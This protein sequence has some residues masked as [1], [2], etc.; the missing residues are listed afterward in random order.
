VLNQCDDGG[1]QTAHTFQ[2]WNTHSTYRVTPRHH[3]IAHSVARGKRNIPHLPMD[4]PARCS[5][6]EVA[7]RWSSP[8]FVHLAREIVWVFAQ[9]SVG[10]TRHDANR[11]VFA[12][13][14]KYRTRCFIKLPNTP[15]DSAQLERCSPPS[16]SSAWQSLPS[17]SH[18]RGLRIAMATRRSAIENTAM[19]LWLEPTTRLSKAAN[20]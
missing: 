10:H 19:C 18:K 6:S 11:T 14:Y 8:S 17:P 12:L 16:S 13:Q 15:V 9:S 7:L 2:T 1:P 4:P 3:L 5:K 20:L